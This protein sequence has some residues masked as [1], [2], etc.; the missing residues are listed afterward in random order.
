MT[1]I[2]VGGKE[3]PCAAPVVTWVDHGLHFAGLGMRKTTTAVC[4][5][6]TGGAGM[7]PQVF[8]TLKTRKLSVHFTVE[9]NGT[10]YQFADCNAYCMH[11][12]RIDDQDGDGFQASANAV[13]VGIEFVNPATPTNTGKGIPR[14]IVREEIHGVDKV[15]TTLTAEQTATG[16]ALVQSLCTAY[17]LPV[18]T[19]MAGQTVLSTVM[20]ESDFRKFRGV[21]GHLHLTKRKVDPGLAILRAIAALTRHP[22]A[23][24]DV[25]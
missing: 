5:H 15:S 19:A 6:H 20:S 9:P 12:G 4:L 1:H 11:A 17:G 2:I 23:P 16:L 22:A 25:I 10:A 18:Q 8:R 21:L 24:P 14:A 3:V 13:T 7:A